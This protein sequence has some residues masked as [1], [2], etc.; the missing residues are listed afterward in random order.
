MAKRSKPYKEGLDERLGNTE[1]AAEYLNLAAE[2]GKADLLMAL[3]DVARAQGIADVARKADRGRESLYKALSE[4]GNPG[5]DTLLSVLGAL[6][7]RLHFEAA[8]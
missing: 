2:E 1:Y 8:G 7:M 5:L 6:G 4:D 3:R